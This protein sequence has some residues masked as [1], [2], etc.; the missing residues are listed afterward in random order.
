MYA[1]RNIYASKKAIIVFVLNCKTLIFANKIG[2]NIRA[3]PSFAKSAE[4]KLP[5]KIE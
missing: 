5:N 3:A 4:T 2:V 1:K